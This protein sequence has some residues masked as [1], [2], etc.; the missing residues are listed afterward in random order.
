MKTNN[1][2]HHEHH[3]VRTTK[4]GLIKQN[5]TNEGQASERWLKWEALRERCRTIGDREALDEAMQGRKGCVLCE[6]LWMIIA[7]SLLIL[8][9]NRCFGQASDAT[10]RSP[11]ARMVEK[12]PW[13]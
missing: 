6:Y 3:A 12:W 5:S 7:V 9:L 10:D 4:G 11:E 1:R 2:K 8:V 13:E